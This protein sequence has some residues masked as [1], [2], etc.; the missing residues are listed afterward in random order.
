MSGLFVDNEGKKFDWKKVGYHGRSAFA[1]VLAVVVLVGM[2]WGG[3]KVAHN[4][5]I[6]YKTTDDYLGAEG[7]ADIVV[8][9]PK[10]TGTTEAGYILVEN[11]VIK[12]VKAWR[13]AVAAAPT[14]VVIQAGKYKMRTEV[15]AEAALAVL[16]D[17]K[18]IQRVTVTLTEGL[19]MSEQWDTVTK[20]TTIKLADLQAVAKSP[21]KLG[22]PAWANNNPEGFLFPDT[23]EVDDN[24]TAT[25][26]MGA[27]V[28][29]F[30]KVAA[31]VN[32]EA[33]AKTLGFTPYQIL[34]IASLAEKEVHTEKDLKLVAGVIMNRLKAGQPLQLDST[35]IYAS[36]VKGRLTTTDEARKSKSPYNTYV[37]KGLTPGPI[38]NPGKMAIEAALNPTKSDFMFFVVTDPGTG[39]TA[40]TKTYAEHLQQVEKFKAWCNAHP[41]KC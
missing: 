38:S 37:V 2:G 32:L 6:S 34:I 3:Y 13:A 4:A 17:T 12:S 18:N 8:D 11:G 33:R 35:V 41:G 7:K 1:V 27:Q 9:I 23:Y 5:Y 21:G 16:Q 30:N 20:K 36:G 28:K 19:R 22:L 31:E 14:D 29:Q 39:E 25:E 10:A 15:S 26:L 40:Y 24:P